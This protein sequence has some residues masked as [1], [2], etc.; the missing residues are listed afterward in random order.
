M[1]IEIF[2]NPFPQVLS[3]PPTLLKNISVSLKT[4]QNTEQD[5]WN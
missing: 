4:Q 3:I 1:V 5:I 2:L